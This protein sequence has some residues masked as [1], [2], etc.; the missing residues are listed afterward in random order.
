MAR[1]GITRYDVEKA[2]NILKS[3]GVNPSIDAIRVEL[4]NTG[5]KTTISRY[6]K[7]LEADEVV[8]LE[9]EALLSAGI[10]DV[11]AKLASK[12]HQEAKEVIQ[13]SE[14]A[15]N[16]RIEQLETDNSQL[17]KE[18]SEQVIENKDKADRLVETEKQTKELLHEH[19]SLK[20]ALFQ[21]STKSA[22][23][24]A[25]E[26]EKDKQLLSLKEAHQHARDS[27][28]HY[29]ESIKEQRESEQ[30]QYE[31]QVQQLQVELRQ[32]NQTLIVK[33]T[34]ITEISRDNSRLYTELQS[35]NKECCKIEKQLEFKIQ[36]LEKNQNKAQLLNLSILELEKKINISNKV[37]STCLKEKELISKQ[38]NSKQSRIEQLET[39][40]NVK[41]ELLNKALHGLKDR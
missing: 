24:E 27:L 34:E 17:K 25:I 18:L 30:R 33:Q 7:E 8:Q 9:D 4:G 11:I 28:E 14:K 10:K 20:E 19:K 39:E 13:R 31:Q 6:L 41:D 38:C 2:H 36:E 26:K 1:S 15:S 23:L 3:R 21:S 40:L 22:K 29:R 37:K 12:L 16:D 35:K 32:L 5:S